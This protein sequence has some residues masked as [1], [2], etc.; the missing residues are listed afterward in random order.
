MVGSK[1]RVGER[2][3]VGAGEWVFDGA[4][5]RGERVTVG[6]VEGGFDGAREGSVDGTVEGGFD[7]A[8]EGSFDGILF[9]ALHVVCWPFLEPLLEVFLFFF[10]DFLLLAF[11]RVRWLEINLAAN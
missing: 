2:V 3:V 4:L 8:G 10:G 9:E 5:E 1:E 11:L 7:G 6:S